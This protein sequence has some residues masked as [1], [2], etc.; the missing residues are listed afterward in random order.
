MALPRQVQNEVC[1]SDVIAWC[2]K[3]IFALA[4]RHLDWNGQILANPGLG[5]C[6]KRSE[7]NGRN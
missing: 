2:L 7:R 1:D 5:E 6:C 4:R 3:I